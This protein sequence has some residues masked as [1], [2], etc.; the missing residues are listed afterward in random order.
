MFKTTPAAEPAP[1]VEVEPVDLIP[2]SVL[3]LDVAEPTTG[4]TAYLTGRGIPIVLDDVGRK[5]VSRADA[6]QLFDEKHESEARR[7]EAVARREREAIEADQLRRAA[8]YKGV[9]AELLPV[10]VSAGDAMAAAA[11]A[12]EPKRTT[13]LQE[14]LS[15]ESM[16]YH[17][18]PST[19]EE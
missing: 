12:A 4:W 10:G 18:L 8:L 11:L 9:S 7:R 15:G 2:L 19:D 1:V 14:A 16:R 3:G 6:R 13:P 17:R 5:S